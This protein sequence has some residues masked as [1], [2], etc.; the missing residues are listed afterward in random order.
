MNGTL[1]S[2]GLRGVSHWWF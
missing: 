2:K 1:M